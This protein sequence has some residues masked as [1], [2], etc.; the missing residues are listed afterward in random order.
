MTNAVPVTLSTDDAPERVRADA[1]AR[2]TSLSIRKVQELAV[3]G[4]VPGAAKL[5]GVW[6]FDPARVRAWIREQ[7]RACLERPKISIS[8]AR[9][10]TDVLSSPDASIDEAYARLVFG[11]RRDDLRAGNRGSRVN[12]SAQRKARHGQQPEQNGRRKFSL[13]QSS[14]ASASDI[15]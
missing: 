11:R 14:R 2:M 3:A 9:R 12:R 1:I 8:E 13:A 10:T 6:T 15:S 4:K 5:G 7:E